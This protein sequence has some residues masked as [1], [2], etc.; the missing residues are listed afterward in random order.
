MSNGSTSVL[1]RDQSLG[2]PHRCRAG[3]RWQHAGPT[4][5]TCTIP[6]FDGTGDLPFVSPQ[7]C[8][9]C[10]GRDDVLVRGVHTHYCCICDG[11]W[12]HE[13]R[14]LDGLPSQCPWCFPTKGS[15]AP[16][17]RTGSHFH[18]CPACGASWRH[19]TACTAP[20]EVALSD[21]SGCFGQNERRHAPPALRAYRAKTRAPVRPLVVTVSLAAGVL[22]SV[23]LGL[24]GWPTF[25][26]AV[27][28]IVEPPSAASPPASTG[29]EQARTEEPPVALVPP[30]EPTTP[31]RREGVSARR[32]RGISPASTPRSREVNL[33]PRATGSQ[34]TGGSGA[35]GNWQATAPAPL[36][37]TRASEPIV[38]SPPETTGQ[39]AAAP[40][41]AS[42]HPTVATEVT[43]P[44]IPGA[45]PSGALGGARGWESFLEG[46]PRQIDRPARLENR[47]RY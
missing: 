46:H 22:L 30:S 20:F 1:E 13:G 6:A 17:T 31:P 43:E 10:C 23:P 25:W 19:T 18:Y 47:S 16:G 3:H 40:I 9:V 14:C 15:S 27:P 37:S 24:K 5:V 45:P 29:P 2:H 4:A 21:C 28:P 33:P 38:E 11:D 12:D 8:A 36:P 26:T 35:T 32:T 7:D 44:S 39:L 34:P 42:A 41:E